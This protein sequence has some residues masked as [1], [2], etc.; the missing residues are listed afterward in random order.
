MNVV[1]K[2]I[3]NAEI[4]AMLLHD[5]GSFASVDLKLSTDATEGAEEVIYRC[6]DELET[7]SITSSALSMSAEAKMSS[8][9]SD[10]IGSMTKFHTPFGA[11]PIVYADWTASARCVNKIE[12]YLRNTVL[13]FYGNTHTATSITGRQ[14][15]AFRHEARQIV[16]EATNAKITG[17]AA[18]DVVLFI[19][20]GTTAAVDKLVAIL[21]LKVPFT[22][23][24]NP[25]YRPVVFVSSYEHHSNLL[26]WRE[27]AAIVVTIAYDPITGVSL[28]D[29]ETQLIVYKLHIIKIGAFAAASN[30]T[31]I[32]SD[33]DSISILLHRYDA[34]ACF[35]YATAAPY[36]AMSMNPAEHPLAY[37]DALY[38]SGHKLLGGPNSSGVLVI[39]RHLLPQSRDVPSSVGGGTVFYVT[40]SHHRYLSNREEREEGGTPML[41]ADVKLGL[42][43]HLKRS[44]GQHWIEAREQ[45]LYGY[46]LRKL[47]SSDGSN[48]SR[49]HLLS[50]HSVSVQPKRALPIFSFLIQCH[51]R[52]LHFHFVAVLLND[53]FGI[54]VRGGCMC[55]GPYAQALLG[56]TSAHIDAFEAALLDKHEVLRPGFTRFSLP[57]WLSSE[58]VE[59]I[60]DAILFIA[61]HGWKFLLHYRYNYKTGEWAHMTR[62][63][64]FPE[65]IWLSKMDFFAAQ[66][67]TTSAVKSA[68]PVSRVG[69]T[70]DCAEAA[71]EF[72]QP[73]H[74]I[75]QQQWTG[76]SCMLDVLDHVKQSV[77]DELHR[78]EGS[79]E[80]NRLAQQENITA[81]TPSEA[82]GYSL[83]GYE[84]LRWFLV[85]EDCKKRS[86]DPHSTLPIVGERDTYT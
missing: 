55:A 76:Y 42:A 81:T 41:L 67:P 34:L 26:P 74:Q 60:L 32:L 24:L 47:R 65:R 30:L 13:Q 9:R 83:R 4:E 17:K 8:L 37:K 43:F 64:R 52:Y 6:Y 69:T 75:L 15:T 29:L 58:E 18:E 48:S 45:D 3:K 63:T 38:C 36:V 77:Q 82:G 2:D 28:S 61:E 16:A 40:T 39:K 73:L 66:A 49:V 11:K 19:G 7:P 59:Y 86:F 50:H 78:L 79:K 25:I 72:A 62:L 54:Q 33:V 56:L 51:D 23:D 14:S 5:G 68:L 53:L 22:T 21:G 1:S 35:D 70:S 20:S 10:I 80:F 12:D 85:G 84:H 71:T 44:V 57:Y 31:G 27:S 46:A